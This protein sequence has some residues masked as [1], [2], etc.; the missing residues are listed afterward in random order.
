L[1]ASGELQSRIDIA[2]VHDESSASSLGDRGSPS[3]NAL[4]GGDLFLRPS[5]ALGSLG[6]GGCLGPAAPLLDP[7]SNAVDIGE[8]TLVHSC[9]R[10]ITLLSVDERADFLC[11]VSGVCGDTLVI[12]FASEFSGTDV[13]VDA[14]VGAQVAVSELLPGLV[15]AFQLSHNFACDHDPVCCNYILH[16]KPDSYPK[17]CQVFN[18]ARI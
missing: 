2:L 7:T 5:R 4:I 1:D 8:E 12:R 13:C 15:S 11:H 6:Y 17:P 18:K 9:H 10:F 3:Q 16:G 14:F